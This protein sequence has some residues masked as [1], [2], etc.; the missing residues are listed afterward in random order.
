MESGG[1]PTMPDGSIW[2]ATAEILVEPDDLSSGRT[3][4]FINITPWANTEQGVAKNVARYLERY[5]WH[6]LGVERIHRFDEGV[7]YEEVVA[8]MVK[9]TRANSDAIILG[10]SIV[11]PPRHERPCSWPTVST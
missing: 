4:W 3:K 5:H 9:R 7:R 11:R 8:D 2:I 10:L 1:Q 6:L